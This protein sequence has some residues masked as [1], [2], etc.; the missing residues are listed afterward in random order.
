MRNGPAEG[1]E[2][3]GSEIPS[4]SGVIS[5]ISPELEAA[6]I[7]SR[8][9]EKRGKRKGGRGPLPILVPQKRRGVAGAQAR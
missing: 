6:R 2:R 8:I 1:Q 5:P 7:L 3:E 9:Y 4:L